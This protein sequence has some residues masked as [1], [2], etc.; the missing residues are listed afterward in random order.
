MEYKLVVIWLLLIL[1]L[2]DL[3][4]PTNHKFTNPPKIKW[5]KQKFEHKKRAFFNA[6]NLDSWSS[7][8]P[9]LL[10]EEYRFTDGVLLPPLELRGWGQ[11]EPVARGR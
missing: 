6:A 4:S 9:R 5:N 11:E 8:G 3:S 10:Q 2:E 7:F 1:Q